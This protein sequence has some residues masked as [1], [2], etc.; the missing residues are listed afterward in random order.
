MAPATHLECL[1]PVAQ[2]S[3]W[4]SCF[5]C[6]AALTS[7]LEALGD[8]QLPG[9]F[10]LQSEASSLGL[11]GWS[12]RFPFGGQLE[13]SAPQGQVPF[14]SFYPQTRDGRLG[15]FCALDLCLLLLISSASCS[16]KSS[17]LRAPRIRSIPSLP[18]Q[19]L[20]P[21][22][23]V[24]GPFCHITHLFID[25]GDQKWDVCWWEVGGQFIYHMPQREQFV[26]KIQF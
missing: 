6:V 26:Q 25:S 19:N 23:Y 13:T 7:H 14:L 21:G 10:K 4:R 18:S 1:L 8:I 11:W 2:K 16:R 5:L 22:L 24:Q 9:T 12:P 3:S 20:A 17:K 15:P